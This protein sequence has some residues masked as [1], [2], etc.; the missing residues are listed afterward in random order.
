MQLNATRAI[1]VAALVLA[2]VGSITCSDN[3]PTPPDLSEIAAI[4]VVSGNGQD[5]MAG[6]PLTS[7]IMVRVTDAT[8]APVAGARVAFLV[9]EDANGASAA[10][11][12]VSANEDGEAATS[13]TL[14]TTIGT[15]TLVAHVVGAPADQLTAAFTAVAAAGPADTIFVAGGQDQAAPASSVLPDSLKVRVTDRFGN[16]VSGVQVNWSVTGGG[17]IS[18]AATT[19]DLEGFTA[20]ARTLGPT[21]QAM[22]GR[23]TA[24]GLRGSPV[25]FNHL[26]VQP[27]S[28]VILTQPSASAA[29]G[30]P[31]AQQPVV[32]VRDGG[33]NVINGIQVVASVESG[34]GILSGDKTVTVSGGTATFTNLALSGAT[35]DQ[36]L[37]FT[38]GPAFA[39]SSPINITAAPAGDQGQWTA[40]ASMPL[41]AIHVTLMPNGKLLMFSR[42]TEPYVWDPT[43]PG[44]FTQ[45][46]LPSNL[47][48]AGHTLL[49]DGRVFVVGGHIAENTGLPDVSIFDPSDN[50]WT[51][52]PDMLVGRWYPSATV[53]ANG[54]VLVL[55]GRDQNMNYAET[56]E[57]WN[58]SSWIRLTGP[59]VQRPRPYYPR[60]FLAPNG[61]TFFAGEEP[62]T[63][64]FDPSGNGHWEAS[65][66]R[67][68]PL[69]RDYGS[70]VMYQPGR[71]LY[72]G[73]GRPPTNT[74]EIIDLNQSS[75][76]WSM[77]GAM[78]FPRRHHNTTLL[79]DGQVFVPGG[80]SAGP[81]FN[82]ES[83]AVHTAEMWNPET[84]SFRTLAANAV[85]RVYHS[86][87]LLLP[88]GRVLFTGSGEGGGGV[89][90]K[91]YE[92]YSPPYLFKGARPVISSAP[93]EVG[94]G[95]AFQVQT[96]DGGSI[97]RVSI[98]RLGSVT[99]AFDQSQR[100]LN[101]GFT[102]TAGGLSITAPSSPNLAPPGHYTLW[103]LNGD[104][105]PSVARIVQIH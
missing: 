33:G 51:R 84:G 74:A 67:V 28:I 19:T 22:T 31:F 102:P 82:D 87:S 55:G 4:T 63:R 101:L 79:P 15:A 49:E 104:G 3:G 81:A 69:D 105:V 90:Q 98:I 35:G 30:T 13:W 71:I 60:M 62:A 53:L 48:C 29:S 97:Q 100:F 103:I 8:S 75:P 23:A 68:L 9:G 52:L 99:H 46:P 34:G 45:V 91:T 36:V 66:A 94:Y 18:P 76:S 21:A 92:F 43:V 88:D 14:P 56:P 32:E 37:R 38:A 40:P 10:P 61:K 27:T 20:A 11:D 64:Y 83:G 59:G 77:T 1:V 26:L 54:D 50:S 89:D 65:I 80:T 25:T 70:A 44:T 72:T 78:A 47:F 24:D 16:A 7:P 42:T 6:Q 93:A 58:G 96:P 95:Q 86:S 12:T 85:D 5:G 17:S 39:L 57:I 2:L 73:G 41:V